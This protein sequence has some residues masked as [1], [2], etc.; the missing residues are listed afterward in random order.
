M[1]FL[2]VFVSLTASAFA[3]TPAQLEAW[4]KEFPKHIAGPM[5]ETTDPEIALLYFRYKA[6]V[7]RV[8]MDALESQFEALRAE[9]KRDLSSVE[10]ERYRDGPT[11]A[12]RQNEM[13]LKTKVRPWLM[14]LEAMIV[15]QAKPPGSR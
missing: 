10:L 12:E 3:V 8:N 15:G 1:R 9:M 11:A 4:K 6:N 13:W 14:K 5:S 2:L 7:S